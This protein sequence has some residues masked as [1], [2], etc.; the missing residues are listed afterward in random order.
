[1]TLVPLSLL[2]AVSAGTYVV[3]EDSENQ[4]GL[5]GVVSIFLFSFKFGLYSDEFFS[6]GFGLGY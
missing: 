4:V 6:I 1:M 5:E 2:S 3:R